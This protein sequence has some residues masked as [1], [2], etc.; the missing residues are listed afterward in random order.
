MII[1]KPLIADI[2][3]MARVHLETWRTTYRGIIADSYL[4]NLSL[5]KHIERQQKYMAM[6]GT[7]YSVAELEGKGIVGFLPG[8]PKRD[9]SFTQPGELYAINILE[10]H[11]RSGIGTAMVRQWAQ[12]LRNARMNAGYLWVLA[13]NKPAIAFYEKL[14]AKLQRQ[15]MIEIGSQSLRELAYGWNDLRKLA[16]GRMEE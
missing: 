6:P 10:Q 15:Q 3:E 12:D 14:G 8:G 5:Q 16:G 13:D 4:E 11:R 7:S 1:R 9:D 2:P